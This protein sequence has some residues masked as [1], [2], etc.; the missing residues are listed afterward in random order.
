MC[1]ELR[2]YNVRFSD[3]D[4]D[5]TWAAVATAKHIKS[6]H[7]TLEMDD[8]SGTWDHVTDLLKHAGQPFADTSIFPVNA[9]CRLMRQRVTVALSGDG[10]DEGFAGYNFYWQV[11]SIAR[12]QTLPKFFRECGDLAL[13][14]LSATGMVAPRF[15]ERL[16]SLTLA[17]N[18]S[19]VQ[20][21][22]CWVREQE[23]KNLCRD[24]NLLPIRRLFEPCW[25]TRLPR[26]ASR[27]EKLFAHVTEANVRLMLP[28]DFLYKVDTASMKESLEIRVPML[29]EELFSFGL[30]M[31]HR[32][33]VTGCTCKRVL[34]EIAKRRVPPSV[35]KKPKRG[36]EIPVDSWLDA[37]FSEHLRDA[38]LG[39]SSGLPEFFR[40]R[41][42]RP[43]IE[44][45]CEGKAY[46]GISRQGL[47]QRIIMLLA[48]HLAVHCSEVS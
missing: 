27:L 36:F 13:S 14:G 22:F 29:D 11:A 32:L 34:R 38:L 37:R 1:D 18:T 21:L 48:V 45:F 40:P 10:G 8:S 42:Y 3:K 26:H 9:V 33:K 28:D 47:Y 4:Y 12:W 5:E 43:I 15:A 35:A 30:S 44:A 20:T 6:R 41:A 25:E 16:R 17:D 24:T 39:V 46:P 2:T 19:I 23:H 31:P 7:E